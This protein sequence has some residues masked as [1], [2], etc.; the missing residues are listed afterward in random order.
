MM[1]LPMQKE[2]QY[3]TQTLLTDV[4]STY[5]ITYYN[6][7]LWVNHLQKNTKVNWL[8]IF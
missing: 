2:I 5:F 8:V 7:E 3:L 4:K 1:I 6:E